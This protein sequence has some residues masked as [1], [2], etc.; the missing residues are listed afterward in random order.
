MPQNKFQEKALESQRSPC[1]V[2]PASFELNK[3]YLTKSNN[4]IIERPQHM[5]MLVSIGIHGY[6]IVS[7][8]G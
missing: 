1:L 6:D 5:F 2:P 8:F 7:L 4:T 3:A